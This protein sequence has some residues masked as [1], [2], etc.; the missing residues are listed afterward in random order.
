MVSVAGLWE[1]GWNT[2]IKEAELWE[3]PLRDFGVD[4]LYMAPVSG[5]RSGY[6]QEIEELTEI[7]DQH[8]A[9]AEIV[10]VD[11]KG[12]T[13]L[14]E[15]QHPENV[16]Y[17]FGKTSLSPLIAYGKP[18]DKSI[19]IETNADKGMLWAHQAA[20]IVLYDRMKKTWQSR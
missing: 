9:T 8:R 10:F 17:V 20:T 5:I 1:L 13:P 4:H 2:P 18:G 12:V 19:R 11:E 15:F 3:Y 16:L 14:A 7:M 6:V